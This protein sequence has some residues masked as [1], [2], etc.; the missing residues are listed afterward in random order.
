MQSSIIKLLT[1]MIIVTQ[2]VTMAHAQ[3]SVPDYG[4]MSLEQMRQLTQDDLASIPFEDL[5]ALVKKFKVSSIDELYQ[6]ILNPT[7]TTASKKEEA[8]FNS[9]LTTTVL[10]GDDIMKSG[11]RTIPEALRLAPGLIVREQTNGNYDV[12]IRGNDFVPPGSNISSAVNNTTLVMIDNRPVFNNFVGS[13]YWE[14]LPIEVT[15]IER[16]EI[17]YGPASALYGPNAV[18]GV[19]H[20]ITRTPDQENLHAET[21]AESSINDWAIAMRGIT[22]VTPKSK[23]RLSGNYKLSKRFQDNYYIPSEGKTVTGKQVGAINA[24]ADTTYVSEDFDSDYDV[25]L[26]K[27]GV[28]L[29]YDYTPSEALHL[30]YDAS[31]QQ[32]DAQVV[33]MQVGSVLNHRQ[34]STV[35][36]NLNVNYKDVEFNLSAVT[37]HLNALVGLPGY[38]Y[39]YTELNTRL[40]YNWQYRNLTLRPGIDA[41]YSMYTDEPYVNEENYEGLINGTAELGTVQT[42]LRADYMAFN[43]LRLTGAWTQG[44]FYKPERHYNAWQ[45]SASFNL[46]DNMLWRAVASKANSSPFIINTFANRQLQLPADVTNADATA[47]FARM[48]N[49]DLEPLTMH[50]YEVG[51]RNHLWQRVQTDVSAFY[52]ITTNYPSVGQTTQIN[53]VP[54]TLP[55]GFTP[56]DGTITQQQTQTIEKANNSDIESHQL[57]VTANVKI[58]LSQNL[59]AT[60]FA[61]WQ[62]T[63]VKNYL[64]IDSASYTQ[65][66]GKTLSMADLMSN[67]QTIDF[68]HQ[69]TPEWY[70]GATINYQPF[71]KFNIASSAYAYSKQTTFY[72]IKNQFAWVNVNPKIIWNMNI[73]YDITKWLQVNANA[74]NV[75]NNE[76]KEFIMTDKTGGS[77][78][79]G[80]TIK[81]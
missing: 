75:L 23:F 31:W 37:G 14:S 35:S 44:Y 20:I 46:T 16:I 36:N 33:S 48:G 45:L 70:G 26:E 54:M 40:G 47:S 21:K 81:L 72:T 73:T 28:N 53:Q 6:M 68:T 27:Y 19:I 24:A 80:M 65:L 76:S 62:Q 32:S 22:Y 52:N 8:V 58:A 39:N 60:V 55:D 10:S 15:D 13:T 63:T 25:A 11:A 78:L 2:S 3:T 57:G 74:R 51:V 34:S 12:H 79:L 30:S 4:N 64:V 59:N 38:E 66:T 56:P 49:P 61:T 5:I 77:Y 50:M 71:R 67:P 43:R 18:S 42:S 29:F 69:Y 17:V 41:N 7:Q 9:P 1:V